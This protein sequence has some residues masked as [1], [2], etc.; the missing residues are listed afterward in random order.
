MGAALFAQGICIHIRIHGQHAQPGGL[1]SPNSAPNV[2]DRQVGVV[3]ER[4]V[5]VEP[6]IWEGTARGEEI[7]TKHGWPTKCRCSPSKGIALR[8]HTRRGGVRELTKGEQ[9]IDYT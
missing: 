3:D 6:D 9:A 8:P 1:G 4:R 7:S 2:V 5:T